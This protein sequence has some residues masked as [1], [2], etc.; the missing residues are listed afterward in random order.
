MEN[1]GLYH[2]VLETNG[3]GELTR[4]FKPGC[5]RYLAGDQSWRQ[6]CRRPPAC[7]RRGEEKSRVDGKWRGTKSLGS[8]CATT[9]E[10]WVGE[11]AQDSRRRRRRT[12][13][14]DA[15]MMEQ[16]FRRRVVWVFRSGMDWACSGHG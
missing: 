16:F 10:W 6:S 9:G 5:R 8:H 4:E 1:S 2:L 14:E 3:E 15:G 12:E 7:A 13:V 11:D